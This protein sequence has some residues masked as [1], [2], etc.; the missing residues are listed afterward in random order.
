MQIMSIANTS[1]SLIIKQAIKTL[2]SGELLIY[3]TETLYG[4]GADATNQQA[5]NK[6]LKY[7]SR[8][9]GKPLSIA[10][11]DQKMAEK[12]VEINKQAENLYKN[13]TPG[14]ITIVSKDK[15]KLAKGIASE[16]KTIGIRIPNYKLILKIIKQYKKPITST[17]ANASNKKR[18]YQLNDIFKNISGK[19]KNLVNLALDAGILPSNPPSVV[20]DTTLSTPITFR[21]IN[22]KSARINLLSHSVQESK[23]IAS[24]ILFKYWDR[25]KNKGLLI[26]I[27][28]QLGAGKTILAK[29]AGIFLNI[30]DEITSPTYSYQNEYKYSKNNTKGNFY[31]LDAWKIDSKKEFKMLNLETNIKKNNVILIEWY[32]QIKQY[33]P[34]KMRGKIINISIKINKNNSRQIIIHE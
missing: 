4:I 18:P 21:D 8:R 26:G 15:N 10:V 19:Q 16:F 28:G 11:S 5:V 27:N 14:P 2:E 31:H 3:P 23:E 1:E 9:E 12:Y 13:F 6:L 20:I 24:K 34:Q 7:K 29:G 22:A 32:D 30:K 17:S 25:C 33:L